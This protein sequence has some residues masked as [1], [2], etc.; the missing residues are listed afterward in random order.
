MGEAAK[1]SLKAIGKQDTHLLSN[2]PEDSLF[3]YN[4]HPRHSEFRKYHNVYN[5]NQGPEATWPFGETIRVELNPKNMG[6]LLNNV[7]I[8]M[9]LPDWNFQDITFNETVQKILFGGKTLAEFGFGGETEA[10]QFRKWWLAGAP[11]VVGITLPLFSF[12]NFESFRSFEQQFDDLLLTLLPSEL[13]TNIPP[14]VLFKL[15]GIV[16]GTTEPGPQLLIELGIKSDTLIPVTILN[17]LNGTTQL[18][19][20]QD[21]QSII[22]NETDA[23]LFALLPD[24]VK[25]IVKGTAPPPEYNLPEIADWAWDLQ[26]LGRKI[27]KNVKFIVGNQ[28]LEEISADWCI[29]HDN[30]YTNDSQ[31]MSAN[32]LYNRNIVGGKTAQPSGQK[33]AQSNEIFIHIPFFFSHN[34]AGDVYS[35]N[36]QNKAPFPL[37]A[38]HN[39]KIILEIEFFKQSF[40]TLYN[41]RKVDNLNTRGLPVTPPPKKMPNFNVV[42]EEIT[43]SPEERLYFMRPNQ[44]IMYDFVFKHSSIPLEPSGREFVVQLEPSVPVKCFHWFFRYEGYEDE[45]EYR[46]LPVSQDNKDT[47]TNRWFYSTTANRFNFTRS[48]IDDMNEPHLLKR[49]YFTLNDERV[50]NVSNNDREYFFSYTPLRSRLS[51]SATDVTRTYDFEPPSPNYLLNYIYTYN[52]AMFPKSTSPSGYLDFSGL[53]SEKTKLYMEMVD[54]TSLQYGNGQEPIQNPEYKFHMYYTGY[55][56]LTFSNG[57]LLQT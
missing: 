10:E 41:Q 31:K 23:E 36:D 42:T 33:A 29:I 30:M 57:F 45:N 44:E 56:K 13:F 39:Q 40:F 22:Q 46:S 2:D 14:S 16:S 12:P 32:T 51:R 53:N 6:D 3:N 27:I 49:A 7:W 15:L 18:A 43:L 50:P 52:F 17:F 24:I 55:K 38:I 34:Y 19:G 1:I 11:N 54:D 48:Q 9:K 25:Q 5:V 28:T 37:C 35:E 21:I 8:Q 20:I 47:Y 4:E 26:L